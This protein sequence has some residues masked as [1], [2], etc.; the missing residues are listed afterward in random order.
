M[1]TWFEGVGEVEC[2]IDEVARDFTDL[3]R[4]DSAVVRR[5]PG[6]SSVDLVEQTEDSVVIRTNEGLMTRTNIRVEHER[7]RLRVEFD[8]VYEAGS[9]VTARSHF[10]DEFTAHAG[11]VKHQVVVGGV[12]APGVLGFLYRKFGSQSMGKAFLGAYKSHFEGLTQTP[13]STN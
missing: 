9:M 11:G 10:K 8:E 12:R 6:L 4:H 1:S 2:T 13:D 3:G 5:M 7:D